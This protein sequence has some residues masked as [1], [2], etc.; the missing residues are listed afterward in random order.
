M[1]ITTVAGNKSIGNP[2]RDGG[3]AIHAGLHAPADGKL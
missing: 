3:L 2:S 1:I